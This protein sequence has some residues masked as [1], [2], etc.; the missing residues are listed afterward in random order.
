ME[1]DL[2]FY[3][4]ML[5]LHFHDEYFRWVRNLLENGILTERRLCCLLNSSLSA[6]PLAEKTWSE[7]G[8]LRVSTRWKVYL[9][10]AIPCNIVWSVQ[11]REGVFIKVLPFLKPFLCYCGAAFFHVYRISFN[12]MTVTRTLL[13]AMKQKLP[14]DV[15]SSQQFPE[16]EKKAQALSLI[17]FFCPIDCLKY[18]WI[19][20]EIFCVRKG[21][22]R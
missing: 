14:V 7:I 22:K 11:W 19:C 6:Y 21:Q 12:C 20:D 1:A 15:F 3:I 18:N 9:L 4:K 13:T 16:G 2:V 5:E 8:E 10:T 17:C